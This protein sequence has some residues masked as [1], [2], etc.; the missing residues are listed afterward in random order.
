[1][2]LK[3]FVP[4]IPL[5]ILIYCVYQWWIIYESREKLYQHEDP[6]QQKFYED[7]SLL[8]DL[9]TSR[10]RSNMLTWLGILIITVLVVW[11]M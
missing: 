2:E 8:Y 7:N 3:Y 1:M 11:L 4:L 6:K 9:L 10:R 5:A